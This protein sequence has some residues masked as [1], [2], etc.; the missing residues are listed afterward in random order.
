MGSRMAMNLQKQGVDL[1]VY[2]RTASAADALVAA[3]AHRAASPASAV[4][5]A[6]IV[7]S[8]LSKP[9]VVDQISHQVLPALPK[10]ALWVDCTTVNPS[11]AQEMGARA[12][13]HGIRYMDAPVAG[14]LP[15]AENAELVFFAGGTE[16]DF[17]EAHPY[18]NHMGK[19]AKHVGPVSRGSA[20]KILINS[21]LAQAMTSFAETVAL[22]Q[23]MGFDRTFL[24]DT[25]S[26]G[27]VAAPFLQFKAVRLRDH[28]L[29]AQFP[30][31]HMRKDLHL[32]AQT[33]YEHQVSQTMAQAAATLYTNALTDFGRQD[34]SAVLAFLE[35]QIN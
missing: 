26:Q 34:F 11:F 33:A 13:Q 10:D 8:M 30:L 3:G 2:N 23:R 5:E 17:Q 20:L 12:E 6:D 16:A 35:Q 29:D 28:I 31:E 7:F 15:H 4:R 1:T 18:F 25:L 21:L 9:E 27:A 14:T 19:A 22:G 32:V 24:L